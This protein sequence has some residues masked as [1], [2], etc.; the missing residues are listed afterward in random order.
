MKCV[1]V[2]SNEGR[3]LAKLVDLEILSRNAL[4]RLSHDNFEVDVVCLSDGE[5][6][7]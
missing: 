3:D 6:S 1:A 7:C 5:N 4:G 2:G